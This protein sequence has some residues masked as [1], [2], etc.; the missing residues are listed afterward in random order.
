[1]ILQKSG[2]FEKV[3][4]VHTYLHTILLA[5]GI[6]MVIPI[7]GVLVNSQASCDRQMEWWVWLAVLH[8][9]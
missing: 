9:G 8:V 5:V 2:V 3:M 4:R 1:V 6:I 7:N